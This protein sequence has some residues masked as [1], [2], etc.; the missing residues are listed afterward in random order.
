M[1][2]PTN[3][4]GA[5]LIFDA[6]C[7]LC[8][9]TRSVMQG[10]PTC[11]GEQVR[12]VPFQSAEA[13]RLLGGAPALGRPDVAYLVTGNGHVVRGLEA[14]LVMLPFLKGGRALVCMLRWPPVY[15][16]AS[17]VY[18]LVARNRYRWFGPVS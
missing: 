8:I 12:Y 7:R 5:T 15:R 3:E 14:F 13:S 2:V 10:W 9:A 6:E 18:Q 11:A 1:R 16:A 4:Y 17:R